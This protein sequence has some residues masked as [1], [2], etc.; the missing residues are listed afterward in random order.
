MTETGNRIARGNTLTFACLVVVCTA[1]VIGYAWLS[2]RSAVEATPAA[3]VT[4]PKELIL[5]AARPHLLFRHSGFDQSFGRLALVPLDAPG[6]P[7]VV[8][9]LSCERSYF[10]GGVGV[11]LAANRGVVTS[12]KLVLF[13]PEYRARQTVPLAGMPSRARVAADGS[14]AALTYFVSGDSYAAA[15]FSTR[16]FVFDP[17]RDQP[18]VNLEDFVV[19][20]DG[21]PFKSVDFNF[22][23]VTFTKDHGRFYSTLSTGGTMYLVEGNAASRTARVVHAGVECPSLSPDNRRVAFKRRMPGLRLRWQIHVLDLTTGV[24]TPLAEE[25]SVDDQVEWLDD[26]TI[27]YALPAAQTSASSDI[28]AVPA[29]GTGAPRLIVPNAASPSVVRVTESAGPT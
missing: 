29:D 24:E 15:S 1:G 7:R 23:G 6:G 19:S 26:A 20:R 17:R 25:R 28:W 21:A 9:S 14:I 2:R 4:D 16:T 22:W 10:A 12:Y 3:E 5:A 27:L 8:T 18:M 11:C 13:D